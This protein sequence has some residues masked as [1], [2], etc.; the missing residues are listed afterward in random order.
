M[1]LDCRYG[2]SAL[3]EEIHYF[4]SADTDS[5]KY[6]GLTRSVD[7][8]NFKNDKRHR[9]LI[10]CVHWRSKSNPNSF[11]KHHPGIDL[12]IETKG[13]IGVLEVCQRSCKRGEVSSCL[14]NFNVTLVLSKSF[15]LK[16]LVLM[17][18][19]LGLQ[20]DKAYLLII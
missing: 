14:Y 13:G 18:L 6:L 5:K 10:C 9:D 19:L 16:S 17:Q 2:M 7:V 12:I 1:I 15:I 8:Q 4:N 3:S 20:D 11:L